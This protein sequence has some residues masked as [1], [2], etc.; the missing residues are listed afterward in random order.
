[1]S[2]AEASANEEVAAGPTKPRR[3]IRFSLRTFLIAITL[4]CCWFGYH[5]YT[6][7]RQQ[8]S[9]GEVKRLGGWIRYDFQVASGQFDPNAKSW[10]PSPLLDALGVD[11]FHHVAEVNFVYSEDH[12]RRSDNERIDRPLPL[13]CLQGLPKLTALFLCNEQASDEN[14]KHVSRLRRLK[15]FFV[16]DA[17][18][19][20][21]DGVRQLRRLHR[22]ENIHLSESGITDESLKVFGQLP[23]IRH[24]SLQFNQFSD[25]GLTHL[26]DLK[27]LES[28]W[29]CG[30]D[31]QSN[32]ITDEGLKVFSSD[33]KLVSLGIQNTEVTAEGVAELKQTYPGIKIAR[34]AYPITSR[35]QNQQP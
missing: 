12:G 9:I 32:S 11:F 20:S 14:L 19:V 34:G 28:L 10:V 18:L 29:V 30:K 4:C 16:W 5:N 21:D 17:H 24:L 6:V 35:R 3:R 1:M 26:R 22:L 8:D 31:D 33:L 27:H 13:E 25:A 15:T 7:Q 2:L 23:E